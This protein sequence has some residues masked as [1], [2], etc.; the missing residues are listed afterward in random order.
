MRSKLIAMAAILTLLVLGFPSVS[1]AYSPPVCTISGTAKADRIIGTSG[2]DIICAG[3][4]ND[5]IWALGGND[6][7]YGESGNDRIYGGAGKDELTGD[8]G[9]D[10]LDGGAGADQLSGGEGNDSISGGESSDTL[11]GG[12]GNDVLEGGA[13][14][15]SVSGGIG[16]DRLAGD[17]GDDILL[18]EVGND[19][20]SG[21]NGLD[22]IDGGIGVDTIRSG[23]GSDMCSEDATDVLLDGCT[24]DASGPDFGLMTTEVRRFSAGSLAV[25]SVKVIDES[26]VAGVQAAIGGAPGWVTEWCGFLIPVELVEGS[27]KAGVYEFSCTIPPNAVNGYYTWEITAFDLM[28]NYTRKSIA[29]E[30]SDGSS[31]TDTPKVTN[32]EIPTEAVAGEPFMISISATDD[33]IVAGIYGWLMLEGGG[34]ADANGLHASGS[35]PRF[36]SEN[37]NEAVVEQEMVFAAQAPAGTYRLW[38]SVRDGV[39]NRDFF[40]TDRTITLKK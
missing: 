1:S 4:G 28:G 10:F 36:L 6:M 24:I 35:E 12:T 20:L 13:G 18:G 23:A 15:D 22:V 2:D 34:F 7:V 38:L 33:S 30:V 17:S 19:N 39:G 32:I 40:D 21:G 8:T 26:G 29:F 27:Q 37:P 25:I 3:R 9:T 5:I 31:D 16:K 11:A 14:A